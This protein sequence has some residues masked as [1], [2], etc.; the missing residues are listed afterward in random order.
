MF[1]NHIILPLYKK[2]DYSKHE[3]STSSM[4]PIK[5]RKRTLTAVPVANGRHFIVRQQNTWSVLPKH[6]V[7]FL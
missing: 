4:V 7:L 6:T 3:R 5:L 2:T 1:E